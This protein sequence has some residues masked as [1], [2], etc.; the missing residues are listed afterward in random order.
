MKEK[1]MLQIW[2]LHTELAGESRSRDF[3]G[4]YYEGANFG[5]NII[6]YLFLVIIMTHEIKCSC[7][8]MTVH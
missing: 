2:W 5:F 3:I 8:P 1:E 4:A 7:Q 6:L